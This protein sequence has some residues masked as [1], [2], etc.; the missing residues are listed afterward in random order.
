MDWVKHNEKEPHRGVIYN[1]V[2]VAGSK[3][4][5]ITKSGLLQRSV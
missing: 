4:I 5:N 1:W 2:K 3:L